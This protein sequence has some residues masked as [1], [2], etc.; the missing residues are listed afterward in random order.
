MMIELTL[1]SFS[2][3]MELIDID[4]PLLTIK[5]VSDK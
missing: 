5:Y 2:Q 3:D 1:D 4:L